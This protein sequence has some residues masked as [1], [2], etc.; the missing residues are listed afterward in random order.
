MSSDR[1]DFSP[2]DPKRDPERFER[3]V[4]KVT[5]GVQSASAPAP[6]LLDFWRWGRLGLVAAAPLALGA[7]LPNLTIGQ[8][9]ATDT[10]ALVSSWAQSGE[11]PA[12][13]D[14]IQ[15]LGAL[16]EQ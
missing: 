10:V 2:L 4:R 9:P 13:V 1:L 16:D 3:M 8:L 5:S 7:W 15:T 11:V 12:N 6:V 14:L